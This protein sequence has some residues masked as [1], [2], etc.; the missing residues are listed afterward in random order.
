MFYRAATFNQDLSGWDVGNG[1]NFVSVRRLILV[2][3]DT[4]YNSQ[5]YYVQFDSS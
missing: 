4:Y 2:C 1:Q 3:Y 5:L